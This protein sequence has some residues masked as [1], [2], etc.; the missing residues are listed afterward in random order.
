MYVFK[1]KRAEK[2]KGL[3]RIHLFLAIF[4]FL[5][6]L[7]GVLFRLVFRSG[8]FECLDFVF[9]SSLFVR[10]TLSFDAVFLQGYVSVCFFILLCVFSAFSVFGY[11]FIP[12]FSFLR[13]FSLGVNMA[14]ACSQFGFSGVLACLLL[15]LPG[16]Y[17]A[18]WLILYA[19]REA[20][21][22]SFRLRRACFCGDP[23]QSNVLRSFF[24]H[25]CFFLC[26]SLLPAAAD[27]AL[28]FLF[29]GVFDFI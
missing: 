9:H 7:L 6:F 23:L 21:A 29:A 26:A 20:M 19:S 3:N 14:V 15:V 4:S 2:R 1:W 13:C 8:F 22:F 11:L 27:A 10:M 24:R 16:A 12:V 5:G 17:G 18:F 25:I 28:A